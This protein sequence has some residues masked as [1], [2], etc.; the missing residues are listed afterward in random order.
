M[1]LLKGDEGRDSHCVE[2]AHCNI[3]LAYI[4]IKIEWPDHSEVS[5]YKDVGGPKVRL[6]FARCSFLHR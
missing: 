6:P 2:S 1:P 3:D 4:R 5:K